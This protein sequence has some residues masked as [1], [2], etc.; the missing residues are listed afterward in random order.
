MGRHPPLEF[1]HLWARRR[2]AAPLVPPGLGL[3]QALNYPAE[4]LHVTLVW[5]FA[6]AFTTLM[7]FSGGSRGLHALMIFGQQHVSTPDCQ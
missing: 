5:E 1:Q 3:A 6:F 7:H 4:A 2:A